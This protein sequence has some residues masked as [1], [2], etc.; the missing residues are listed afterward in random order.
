MIAPTGSL[1]KSHVVVRDPE[2]WNC[3]S[4]RVEMNVSPL[5]F[6]GKDKR[7]MA[8]FTID[9]DN[10]IAALAGH[11]AGAEESQSFQTRRNWR[12]SLRIGRLFG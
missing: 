11:S 2:R 7:N 9:S 1:I 5:H 6:G 8:T 10:N 3:C 12:N 4:S